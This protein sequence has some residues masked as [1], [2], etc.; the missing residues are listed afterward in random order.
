MD[1]EHEE[2][3]RALDGEPSQ[4][5]VA[6][7]TTGVFFLI[8]LGPLALG[9]FGFP[10][11]LYLGVSVAIHEIGHLLFGI[12]GSALGAGR[13]IGV[14][15]GTFFEYMNP[16]LA[17]LVF[18][19]NRRSSVLALIFLA[20]IGSALPST[21]AYMA[22]A[23]NP[24]GTSYFGNIT[25][26]PNDVNSNNHDWSIMLSALGLLGKEQ[27]IAP[28]LTAFGDALVLCGIIGAIIGFWLL[29]DYRA[30]PF[31]ELL[32]AGSL[33]AAAV[34]LF[35]GAFLQTSLCGLLVFIGA[36]MV[37]YRGSAELP[38]KKRKVDE[39]GSS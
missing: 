22:T 10:I 37:V 1:G 35:R 11:N 29:M 31:P 12:I 25:G 21:A 18:A 34:F 6:I 27:A 4:D 26:R 28:Y 19:R 36:G 7:F 16:L 20:C 15:G 32:I 24:Y 5:E 3:E 38:W 30:E 33:P 2:N 17:V 13:L 39:K 8:F 9:L 23:S 14:A